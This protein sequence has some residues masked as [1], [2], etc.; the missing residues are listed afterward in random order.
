MSISNV[1]LVAPDISIGSRVILGS[2]KLISSTAQRKVSF[3]PKSGFVRLKT[4]VEP[5]PSVPEAV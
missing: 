1:K 4:S 2:V 3:P 5:L